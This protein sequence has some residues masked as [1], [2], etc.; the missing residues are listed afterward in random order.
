[1][2]LEYDFYAQQLNVTIVHNTPTPNQHYI[3]KVEVWVNNELKISEDYTSQPTINEF[4]YTYDVSANDTD[5]IK[6]TATCNIAGDITEEI[7]VMDPT[8]KDFE[9]EIT[10]KITSIDEEAEQNFDVEV[11]YDSQH[12]EDVTLLV[13]AEEGTINWPDQIPG[14]PYQFI[15]TA[16]EV[17]QDTTETINITASKTGFNTEYIEIQFKIIDLD[18]PPKADID[19]ELT[20]E[21]KSIEEND[22]RLLTLYINSSGLPLGDVLLDISKDYGLTTEIEEITIGKYEFGYNAPEVEE[23]TIET[24]SVKVKKEGYNDGFLE[25]KFTIKNNKSVN[26]KTPTLDGI[27]SSD[28]YEFDVELDS[29]NYI[30]HWR[31]EDDIIRMAME[32]KTTGWVAIGFD[33]E[34][35]MKGADMVIGWV[36][37]EDE[38][39]ILDCY[40]KNEIG[41]HPPDTEFGGTDDILAFGGSETNGKTI[42]E[43]ERYLDTGDSY[44]KRLPNKDDLEIIWAYGSE[45]DY[46]QQHS[47]D[48]RGS[49]T[50]N[51]ATGE[52]KEKTELWL[53]HAIFMVL[54]FIFII[55]G[56]CIAKG[57]RKK[58]WWLKVHRTFGVLGAVFGIIGI[59]V[60]IYMVEDAGTGHL[61]YPHSVIGI[62]TIILL[63]KTPILGYVITKG[64]ASRNLKAYHRWIGRIAT[65]FMVITLLSGLILKGII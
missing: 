3:E 28:E 59:L 23:D 52:Y 19:L 37:S 38:V 9:L 32:V 61:R 30:I 8:L 45:D 6:V 43:F 15:Y 36:D 58:R 5:I 17:T 18:G 20:P 39:V 35:R 63:V 64:R 41:E 49:G 4:T 27:I 33:P 13:N 54:G 34:V 65:L 25:I 29:D 10:P 26:G 12:V 47:L 57:L 50:I 11:T 22:Y 51:L 62:I 44:D 31:I 16:P 42:I 1:M 56:N 21:M 40:S 55:I 14:E 60:A 46:T 53:I 2:S 48:K 7:T 24:L